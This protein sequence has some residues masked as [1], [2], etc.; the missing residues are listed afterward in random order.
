VR[1]LSC[2]VTFSN[3][4]WVGLIIGLFF[5]GIGVFPMALYAAFID[6]SEPQLGWGLIE[7]FVLALSVL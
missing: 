2:G 7:W 1:L 5:F 3:F 6:I 4:G